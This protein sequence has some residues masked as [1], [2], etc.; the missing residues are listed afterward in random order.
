MTDG[1]KEYRRIQFALDKASRAKES[2]VGSGIRINSFLGVNEG[3]AVRLADI[4]I[5]IEES[6]RGGVDA[7]V[8]VLAFYK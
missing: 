5:D 6:A 4:A 7:D 8:R 3:S 2:G 1:G